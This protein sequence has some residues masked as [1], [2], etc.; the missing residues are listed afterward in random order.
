M[1]LS[2]R[3]LTPCMA[4]ICALFLSH[5]SISN[6]YA[7]T[8]QNHAEDTTTKKNA[9]TQLD[10]SCYTLDQNPLWISLFSQFSAAYS[11]KDYDKALTYTAQ[12]ETI[13]ARS[14]VLN[15]S[16]ANTYRQ[17]GNTQLAQ[18]Y[19]ETASLN[20]Q[21]F[22]TSDEI[23]KKIWFTR[24]E[25]ENDGTFIKKSQYE[26]EISEL[27]E[28]HKIELQNEKD[29][30]FREIDTYKTI[31]WTGTG[32]GVAGIASLIT[33]AVLAGTSDI[34]TKFAFDDVLT[35]CQG[36]E[37]SSC[38]MKLKSSDTA[39]RDAGYALVGVGIAATIA[40]AVMAGLGGYHY[41]RLRDAEEDAVSLD[42]AAQSIR[43]NVIF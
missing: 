38:H 23:T 4:L 20:L 8:P 35:A 33:G 7:D 36:A 19:I 31:M 29:A 28:A 11:A 37:N 42:I 5:I 2:K 13:C 34:S 12:L 1:H 26:K 6:V 40:G 32:I 17:K 9:E 27:N 18:S 16:I 3:T 21:E 22:R 41:K 30:H 15:F 43:L 25:L 14:P 39:T 10:D 24:Y